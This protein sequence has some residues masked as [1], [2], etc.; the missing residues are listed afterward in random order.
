MPLGVCRSIE[1]YIIVAVEQLMIKTL[2]YEGKSKHGD[3]RGSLVSVK[4]AS[5]R[6][7]LCDLI[8]GLAANGKYC[9]LR[10]IYYRSLSF[11]SGLLPSQAVAVRQLEAIT[12]KLGC[13]RSGIEIFWSG[14]TFISWRC[15]YGKR[16]DSL[17]GL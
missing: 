14:F 15:R 13:T 4:G 3:P 8:H 17:R 1:E 5:Q 10:S 2:T 11:Y 7:Y 16:I 6:F 12:S 9:T